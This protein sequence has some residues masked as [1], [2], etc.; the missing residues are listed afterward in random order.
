MG[1]CLPRGVETI[2]AILAVWK[3]GA[4]YLPIDP[5]QPA[6]RVAF[7][8]TDSGAVTLLST[9]AVLDEL[10][11]D[12]PAPLALDAPE[13]AA[14]ID[15]HAATAPRAD[16]SPD[17][18]AYVIYTSGSTGTPKG[19]AVTHRS[20]TNYVASVPGRVGLG[21]PGDRYALLQA[22][23]T[24]LGNTVLFAS[25]TTG[26]QLHIL[27]VDATTDPAAVTGYLSEHAIDH[28]KAVPSHLAALAVA[29]GAASVLPAK[30][31]VLGGEAASPA[32]VRE[33]LAESG[34]RGVFNHYGPTETTIG[35]TTTRL[36]PDRVE[37]GVVPIGSPVPN[38]RVYVLDQWLSPVAPGAVGELYVAGAALA[39]GYVGRAALTAERFVASPYFG[40]GERMYRTG[41][42]VRWNAEGQLEYLGRAD[43]QVKIRGFRIEPGEVQAVV[44]AHPS[45]AQAAVVAREDTTGDSR[46]VAYVVPA[47]SAGEAE[48]VPLVRQF[49]AERLP[50]HMVPSAVMVLDALP[51][52]ANGKLDRKALP[53]PEY[54]TGSGRGPS[55]VREEIL[56][57]GFAEVLGLESVGVDDSFFALGGHSL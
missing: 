6:E 53:A 17:A 48:L 51:L 32:W 38:V 52:S 4:G 26:G 30:S 33:L 56:C 25:L 20:L 31:L 57:A 2:A 22:Q 50:E 16:P 39:R 49:V 15:A 46:L 44:A 1:L 55:S 35:V 37:G 14:A 41:D 5:E 7:M 45:V 21:N 43:E 28:V 19:V 42:R 10:S 12:G 36:T 9:G 27:D 40:T 11:V 29:D 23:V 3:A 18:L 24:D 8:L 13:V 34:P 54:T 47:I